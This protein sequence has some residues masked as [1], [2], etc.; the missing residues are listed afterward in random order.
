AQLLLF[1]AE[2]AEDAL[3]IGAERFLAGDVAVELGDTAGEFGD[4]LL[5]APFLAVELVAG[6][7]QALQHDTGLGRLV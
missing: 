2:T 7:H 6:D 5:G 4:P 3:G 1:G